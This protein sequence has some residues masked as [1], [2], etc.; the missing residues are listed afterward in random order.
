MDNLKLIA[1]LGRYFV[2][3]LKSNRLVSLSPESGYVHLDQ[4]EWEADALPHGQNVKLKELPFK[5]RLFK[6]VAPNGDIEWIITNR[7]GSISTEFVQNENA[8]RW[9]TPQMHRELKQLTGTEKCE[10]PSQRS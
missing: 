5:V 3:T 1:R 6:V 8:L 9:Q 10:C 2:T 4:L 7:P